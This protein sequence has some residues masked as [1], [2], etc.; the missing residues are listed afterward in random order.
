VPDVLGNAGI[1]T[2]VFSIDQSKADREMMIKL[3]CKL[4]TPDLKEQQLKVL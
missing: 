2:L 4:Y 3:K 1:D